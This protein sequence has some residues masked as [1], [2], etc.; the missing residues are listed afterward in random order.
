MEKWNL[1]FVVITWTE[2]ILD[3]QRL[4]LATS[5]YIYFCKKKKKYNVGVMRLDL[6]ETEDDK[7]NKEIN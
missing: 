7:G 2:E 6:C 3:L 5:F 1:R 4:A